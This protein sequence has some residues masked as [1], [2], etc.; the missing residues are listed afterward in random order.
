MIHQFFP[1]TNDNSLD[2]VKY[3][4]RI[5]IGVAV[6]DAGVGTV[7]LEHNE[8][9]SCYLCRYEDG[10]YEPDITPHFRLIPDLNN[11]IFQYKNQWIRIIKN[12]SDKD[13]SENINSGRQRPSLSKTLTLVTRGKNLKIFHDLLSECRRMY[14]EKTKIGV[15]MWTSRGKYWENAGQRRKRPLDSVVLD[16]GVL[17]SILKDI[18]KFIS[19]AKWYN[20]RGIPYRRGY[21]LYG[22]PGCGKTSIISAIAGYLNYG[23]SI[24]SLS[25]KSL[26][27]DDVRNLVNSV[28]QRSILL[29]EDIDA[30]FK[31][32]TNG[33]GESFN[34]NSTSFS[35]LLNGL[36]GVTSIDA[37]ILF[38][39]TNYVD[40]LDPALIRPGR[41]DVKQKIDYCSSYQVKTLFTRFY[42]EKKR[43]LFTRYNPETD[44]VRITTLAGKFLEKL[45]RFAPPG[46]ELMELT[47]A[48]LQEYFLVHREDARDAIKNVEQFLR[49][50][51]GR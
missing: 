27:D 30:A 21:L 32:R 13:N 16:R 17:E 44:E 31:S 34:D 47:P 1:F 39:T 24:L 6:D 3:N 37:R 42:P 38:M 43:T 46:K 23:I 35:G 14:M 33:G 7:N 49:D 25:K 22:P 40:R 50:M 8:L 2:L 15:T 20:D 19:S 41:V 12:K 28:P 5:F 9:C 18:K 48:Q 51:K 11:H 26:D 29:L 45:K 10:Q 4:Y 36:D